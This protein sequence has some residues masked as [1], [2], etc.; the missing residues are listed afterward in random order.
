MPEFKYIIATATGSKK[1]QPVTV[2]VPIIFGHHVAHDR[3]AGLARSMLGLK[4]QFRLTDV[5]VASA[6]MVTFD[7]NGDIFTHGESET[8]GMKPMPGDA[9]IISK[10]RVD[11]M[12]DM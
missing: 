12:L 6:G 10:F 5:K 1:G 2:Q 11:W 8:L 9:D 3:M 7:S 4:S